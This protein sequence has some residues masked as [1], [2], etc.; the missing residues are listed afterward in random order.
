VASAVLRHLQEPVASHTETA[1]PKPI[2]GWSL[3]SH[4]RAITLLCSSPPSF[5]ADPGCP[6]PSR[7]REHLTP[8]GASTAPRRVRRWRVTERTY[9]IRRL[10]EKR[11]LSRGERDIGW[12]ETQYL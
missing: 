4:T 8:C 12:R 1:P 10:G 9:V 6:A 2:P 7:K 11:L 5:V 3:G